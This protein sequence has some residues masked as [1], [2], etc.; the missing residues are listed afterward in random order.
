MIKVRL[1]FSPSVMLSQSKLFGMSHCM[2]ATAATVDAAAEAA[3]LGF[4]ES[5]MD[6]G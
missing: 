1:H 5:N 4:V 2:A 6:D 3:L